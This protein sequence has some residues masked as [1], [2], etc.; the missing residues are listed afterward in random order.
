MTSVEIQFTD[1]PKSGDIDFLT[2][3]INVENPEFPPATPFA[4]FIKDAAGKIIAGANGLLL[5]GCIY[6]DQLWVDQ[7]YRNKGYAH[8][9][10]D[11]IHQYG[12]EQGCTMATLSTMSFQNALGLY[13]KLGYKIDFEREGYVQS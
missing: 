9:L 4:F 1:K 11:K 5:V 10:M 13:Q 7:A 8:H 12:K 3:K 2:D 6:T